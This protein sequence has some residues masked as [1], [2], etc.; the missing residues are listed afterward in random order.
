VK[1]IEFLFNL[2]VQFPNEQTSIGPFPIAAVKKSCTYVGGLIVRDLAIPLVHEASAITVYFIVI[3][4]IV[5]AVAFLNPIAINKC[6]AFGGWGKIAGPLNRDLYGAGTAEE[7]PH[8]QLVEG[9]QGEVAKGQYQQGD[10]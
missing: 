2:I 7:E 9:M 10:Q 4:L 3:D 6:I 5:V 1:I 8:L